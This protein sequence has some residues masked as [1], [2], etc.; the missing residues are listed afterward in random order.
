MAVTDGLGL[1][2]LG[3]DMK[4]NG[5]VIVD[6]ELMTSVD[7]VYAAGASAGVE[8]EACRLSL[9]SALALIWD[10][11]REGAMRPRPDD[12]LVQ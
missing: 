3:I 4:P 7:G 9:R 6:E 2:D 1:S 11:W 10:E 8:P 5:D 12:P